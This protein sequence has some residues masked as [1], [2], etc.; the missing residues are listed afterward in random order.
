MYT[1]QN[2]PRAAGHNLVG[3]KF[4]TPALQGNNSC[5][6]SESYGKHK[7]RVTKCKVFN[8]IAAVQRLNT[9]LRTI[10]F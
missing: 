3:R 6:L 10:L 9:A 2:P 5:L 7:L 8:D 1:L 4:Y